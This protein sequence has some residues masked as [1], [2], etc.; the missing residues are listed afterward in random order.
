MGRRWKIR[1]R[2]PDFQIQPCGLKGG[3]NDHRTTDRHQEDDCVHYSRK[4]VMNQGLETCNLQPY[5]VN[6]TTPGK[7][8]KSL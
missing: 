1:D 4:A 5:V 7:K 3:L 6:Y 2:V 8:N